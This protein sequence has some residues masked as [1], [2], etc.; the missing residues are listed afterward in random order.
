MD[1]TEILGKVQDIFRD[2]FG[3]SEL[4]IQEST[5]ANDIEGWDSL[6]HITILESVQDEFDMKFT[7][8]EM[9]ELSDIGKMID[10]IIRKK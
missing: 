5:N 6:T 10:V 4:I 8:E 3:D 2:V 1:R 9:I 7:L